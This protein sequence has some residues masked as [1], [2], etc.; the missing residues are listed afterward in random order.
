MV[1]ISRM[2]L[3]IMS[4]LA[5]R[6]RLTVSP[7][8]QR[9][10]KKS[11]KLNGLVVYKQET[12]LLFTLFSGK[13]WKNLGNFL[14]LYGF[15]LEKSYQPPGKNNSYDY[16]HRSFGDNSLIARLKDV[17]LVSFDETVSLT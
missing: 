7:P 8:P 14:G 5:N 6:R 4:S 10:W 2:H 16:L 12:Y 13:F 9:S 17:N 11:T 3:L 15:S 1:L